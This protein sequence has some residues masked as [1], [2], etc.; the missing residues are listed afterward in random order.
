MTRREFVKL[1]RE[2][3]SYQGS[4][5]EVDPLIGL[6]NHRDRVMVTR[7]GAIAFLRWQ[8]MD[9][10]GQSWDTEML[11]DLQRNFQRVDIIGEGQ[12]NPPPQRRRWHNGEDRSDSSPGTCPGDD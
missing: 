6:A 8:A 2:A 1:V 11:E 7:A 12:M 5:N 4:L 9:L 3:E 10:F